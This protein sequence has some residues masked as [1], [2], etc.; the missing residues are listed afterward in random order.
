MLVRTPRRNTNAAA[1]DA[2]EV[3]LDA[4]KAQLRQ[5]DDDL[6]AGTIDAEAHARTREEIERRL[7]DEVSAAEPAGTAGGSRTTRWVLLVVL[8]VVAVALYAALGSPAALSPEA[9]TAAAEPTPADVEAMVAKLAERM[10]K[11]PP[12]RAEDLEGWLM[13][14]RSYAVLQRWPE[15][16]RAFARA[17]ELAPD[18]AQLLVDQADVL[19]M[20]HGQSLQGEPQKL[21]DRALQLDPKNPKA[22]ALA[23][24]AAFER[25]D[26]AAAAAFWQRA[27]PF[28]PA[29]SE[30]AQGLE[31]SIAEAR[32]LAGASAPAGGAGPAGGA[33]AR[34]AATT[35]SA[36]GS[37]TGSSTGS[38]SGSA[39]GSATGSETAAAPVAAGGAA[40]RGRVAVAP[41]LASRVAPT[42]TVF[43]FARAAE[44]PKMPLA[45]VKRPA[46]DLPFDFTLDDAQ[47]MAPQLKLSAHPQVIVGVRVSKTGD[48][49]PKSGDLE[50][51][52][53]PLP[54]RSDQV[55]L[56]IDRVRP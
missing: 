36:T 45:I 53:G 16:S 24:S 52:A 27:Q 1:A 42:D 32:A 3:N 4:L 9:R 15:A 40:I 43:V 54:N 44:G 29:G 46:S 6:A 20:A 12:G 2:A 25:Q 18:D 28:A 50:G 30:F 39:T 21:I 8:P 19:A 48:A 5:L 33:A 49:M 47:A 23:G 13:L 7:L 34:S 55:E 22:L 37:A 10:D 51:Q 38:S 26:Y 11:Q 41:A 31:R 56:T 14:G 35:D 17:I